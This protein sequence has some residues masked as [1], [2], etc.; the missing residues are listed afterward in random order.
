MKPLIL[1]IIGLLA[2]NQ[3]VSAQ[4]PSQS[5]VRSLLDQIYTQNG[6]SLFSDQGGCVGYFLSNKPNLL[7]LEVRNKDG[8]PVVY[9][10]LRPLLDMEGI[11][12][13]PRG[14]KFEAENTF[15]GFSAMA[16]SRQDRGLVL[17]VHLVCPEVLPPTAIGNLEGS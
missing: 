9:F 2:L 17:E 14:W 13:I 16:I 3:F 1:A 4:E 6:Y 7:G 5:E 11:V 10:L 12:E 8:G 15:S